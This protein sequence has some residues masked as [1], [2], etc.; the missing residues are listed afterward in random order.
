MPDLTVC[1]HTSSWLLSL[2]PT[3]DHPFTITSWV[4]LVDGIE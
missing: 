2:L 1:E 3:L 4:G